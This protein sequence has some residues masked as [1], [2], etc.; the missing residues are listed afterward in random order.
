MPASAAYRLGNVP[1]KYEELS[2][3]WRVAD[4]TVSDLTSPGREPHDKHE[5][6]IIKIQQKSI[7]IIYDTFLLNFLLNL[8]V[9]NFLLNLCVKKYHYNI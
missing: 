8:C 3:R 9:K 1:S 6:L 2:Q 7:I 5:A 4:D